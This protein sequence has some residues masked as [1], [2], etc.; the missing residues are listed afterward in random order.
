[1]STCVW[2]VST[3]V[4]VRV[5]MYVRLTL[6]ISVRGQPEHSLRLLLQDKKHTGLFSVECLNRG[7]C[8]IG[9]NMETVEAPPPAYSRPIVSDAARVEQASSDGTPGGDAVG[10]TDSAILV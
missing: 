4:C 10:H 1:M 8:S 2:I 9:H 6:C 7:P 5:H 3:Y